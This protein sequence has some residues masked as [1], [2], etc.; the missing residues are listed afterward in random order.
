MA[1][2]NLNPDRKNLFDKYL[3]FGG[4][5]TGPKMF[6]GGL[7]VETLESSNAQEIATLTA[8][9]SVPFDR[10]DPRN[11]AFVVDFE[12]CLKGFL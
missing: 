12:G 2:R 9:H 10:S 11:E 5:D 4:I 8:T 6:S 3:T 1:K 7:D